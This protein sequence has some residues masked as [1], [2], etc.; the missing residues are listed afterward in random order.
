MW[1]SV[2]HPPKKKNES[3]ILHFHDTPRI[4]R[5]SKIKFSFCLLARFGAESWSGT[6]GLPLDSGRRD[7]EFAGVFAYV[8]SV[9]VSFVP[10]T[11]SIS[12]QDLVLV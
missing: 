3:Y 2:R 7:V 5:V 12:E 10:K 6:S 4:A 8:V 11:E 9:A 1:G